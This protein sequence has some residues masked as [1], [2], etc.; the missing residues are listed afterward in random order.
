MSA[1]SAL[2]AMRVPGTLVLN[3]TDLTA[4]YPH[5]GT[6]LGLVRDVVISRRELTF[7]VTAEEF[8]GEIADVLYMGEE[9]LIVFSLRG[10]DNDAIGNLF[11]NTSLPTKSDERALSWPGV[12]PSGIVAGQMVGGT[13]SLAK[14]VFSPEDLGGHK[15]VYF[16]S[17]IP[18]VA[19]ELELSMTRANEM[20]LSAG[21]RAL[22]D[23]STPA[24]SVQVAL[25]EDITL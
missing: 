24:G 8:G 13:S 17:A 15:G 25:L 14:I 22:R 11:F 4:A 12:S 23:P 18:E 19:E 16:R 21:F 3:P 2:K 10:W 1:A 6:P 5:G 20:T 9:W 7:E